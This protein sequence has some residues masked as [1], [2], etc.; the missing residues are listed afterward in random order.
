MLFLPGFNL[1][2]ILKK[3]FSLLRKIGYS[4]ITSLAFENTLLFIIYFL[5]YT[6]LTWPDD[7]SYGPFIGVIFSPFKLNMSISLLNIFLLLIL[8]IKSNKTYETSN[9]YNINLEKIKMLSLKR[10]IKN[11]KFWIYISY[12]SS[13]LF[14]CLITFYSFEKITDF[15]ENWVTYRANFTF[16]ERVFPIFYPLLILSVIL[17]IY[18]LYN[19]DNKYLVLSA[20]AIFLYCIWILPYLQIGYYF[21]RDSYYTYL[22][23]DHYTTRGIT[24]QGG[25]GFCIVPKFGT[26]RYSTALFTSIILFSTTFLDINYII[27]YIFPLIFIFLPFFF[28]SIFQDFSKNKNN[29]K[30]I[31]ISTIF[32]LFSPQFMKGGH[33]ASTGLIGIWIFFILVVELYE[34]ITRNKIN[35]KNL[36]FIG[37][38]YFFL[39]L[40]H[41]EECIYFLVLFSLAIYY[42]SFLNL[43]NLKTS[44]IIKNNTNLE[45]KDNI[46]NKIVL[47]NK[48]KEEIIKYNTI[49]RPAFFLI[50]FLAIL[51]LIFYST[52]EFFG[53]IYYHFGTK[54]YLSSIYSY[55]N[56]MKFK[57]P[58]VL[59]GTM[60]ISSSVLMMILL[61][62][63]GNTLFIKFL[64]IKRFEILNNFYNFLVK[65][66]KPLL[67]PLK[68]I[69]SKKLFSILFFPLLLIFIL[70]LDLYNITTLEEPIHTAII[71]LILNYLGPV[72]QILLFIKGISYYQLENKKQNFFLIAIISCSTILFYFVITGI[73]FIALYLLHTK[74]LTYLLFFNLIIIQETYLVE[75]LDKNKR[76]LK[77]LIF[78]II[79]LGIFSGLRT[80]AYG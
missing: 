36:I 56:Q 48:L 61:I 28:Y 40:T 55:Y 30:C 12:C 62:I 22:I 35:R 26:Q 54:S 8:K 21:N 71:G 16:F 2:N 9:F 14:L 52:F 68:K 29:S 3:D 10:I 25:Y 37:F 74:F 11:N 63:F 20:L 43:K 6:P 34:I 50:I 80:L 32:I 78:L 44:F 27:W 19:I 45:N 7:T 64:L 13:L 41:I 38:L 72:F 18:I 51:I 31:L 60:K 33:N 76:N 53:W 75:F 79:I 49:F 67:N 59:R 39:C 15:K 65:I 4:I 24:V 23:Y 57:I 46:L 69:V 58:F 66:I 1:I 47:T 70:F 42:F 77:K 73:F 5:F 17:L